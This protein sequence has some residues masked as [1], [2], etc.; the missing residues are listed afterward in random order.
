MFGMDVL[1]SHVMSCD[2]S[3]DEDIPPST[4]AP[5]T[6]DHFASPAGPSSIATLPSS[7]EPSSRAC[8]VSEV[9]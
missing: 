6:S 4:G 3:I 2:G 8:A 7:P 9:G 1:T 5:S